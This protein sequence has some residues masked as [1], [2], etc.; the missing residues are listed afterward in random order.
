MSIRAC[1]GSA[2]CRRRTSSGRWY[3]KGGRAGQILGPSRLLAAI[4]MKS[5]AGILRDL[6][7]GGGSSGKVD[8]PRHVPV[9]A[10]LVGGSAVQQSQGESVH[11][12]RVVGISSRGGL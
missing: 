2:G 6:L 11:Q 9:T 5:L 7:P 1:C 8:S 10:I 12:L 4:M 3:V